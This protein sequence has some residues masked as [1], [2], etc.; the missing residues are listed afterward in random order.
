M[1]VC[2]YIKWLSFGFVN[3]MACWKNGTEQFFHALIDNLFA[4]FSGLD[5]L[6]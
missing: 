5:C 2:L 3:G 4:D 1:V 6:D